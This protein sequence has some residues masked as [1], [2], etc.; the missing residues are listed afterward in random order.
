MNPSS[1]SRT[2]RNQGP[3]LGS[4]SL[5]H[6]AAAAGT[7]TGNSAAARAR[8]VLPPCNAPE[9]RRPP[10][11]RGPLRPGSTWS[12]ELGAHTSLARAPG[13]RSTRSSQAAIPDPGGTCLPP[14]CLGL[15]SPLPQAEGTAHH[16]TQRPQGSSA[17][18]PFPK[19]T[20]GDSHPEPG[21]LLGSLEQISQ[22]FFNICF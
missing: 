11:L 1:A 10:W 5:R 14:R 16:H 18:A 4:P 21:F 13:L 8:A 6:S 22:H 15:L 12:P 3:L 9:L 2:T 19:L 20:R 17:S 7:D